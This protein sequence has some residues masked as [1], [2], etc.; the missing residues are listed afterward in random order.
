MHILIYLTK[1]DYI[2]FFDY[3]QLHGQEDL[4]CLGSY[5]D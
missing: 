3:I 1:E 2:Y 4:T 5:N